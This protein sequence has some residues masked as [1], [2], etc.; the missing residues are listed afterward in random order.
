[1]SKDNKMCFSFWL[2][3]AEA[4]QLKDSAL[5]ASKNARRKIGIGEIVM[6]AIISFVKKHK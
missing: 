2:D 3:K 1:M 4:V 5:K 6:P